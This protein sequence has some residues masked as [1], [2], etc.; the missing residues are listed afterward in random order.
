MGI[1]VGLLLTS[2]ADSALAQG[3][4]NTGLLPAQRAELILAQMSLDEKLAMVQAVKGPYVG[5]LTNNARLGIPALC[6]EDG[7]AGVANGTRG[8]TAFPAP[9]CIGASWDVALARDYGAQAAREHRHKGVNVMLAPMMNLARVPQSG[10][11]F[12]GYGEEPRLSGMLAAAE[13]LGIQGQGTMA[14]IKHFVGNDQETDRGNASSDMDERTLQEVYNEPFRLCVRAGAASVMASYN[15][16]HL[17]FACESEQLNAT[18]KKRWGFDGFVETDWYAGFST[19]GGASH[20]LDIEMYSSGWFGRG[21]LGTA[22]QAG[23]VPVSDLD[24]MVRRVLGAMFRFGLFDSPPSGSLDAVVTNVAH[25]QFARDA[26]AQGMVL[27]KN[28]GNLLPLSAASLRSIAVIGS[29]ADVSPISVGGGSA[30]V[31]LPYNITPRTGI[32]RRAGAVTINYAQGDGA[33]LSLAAQAAANSDVAIVC[34]GRQTSEGSD[35]SSLSLP[36]NQD[37][38]ISAVA[39]ANP[40]TIVVLYASGATL[41]PWASQ[42]AGIVVA[43]FPGQENGSALASVLFGDVNPSGKLPVTFPVLASQVPAGTPSRFP[44]VSGHVEYS[45]GLQIGYRWYDA[46]NVAPLFCFGHGLSYTTFG[47]SNLTVSAVNAAGQVQIGFDL[48]NTGSRAGAEVAQLYLGYPAAANEPPKLLKRFQKVTLS[49]GETRHVVFHLNWEDMAIWDC[50]ARGWMVTPGLFQVLV[51]ASSRDLR[52]AGAFTMPSVPP[53]DLANAALHR[54]ATASSVLSTNAAGSLCV[55]GDPETAWNSQSGG[56]QSL[57]LDLGMVRDLS[58]IRLQWATNYAASYAI[59]L[60]RDGLNWSGCRTNNNGLGGV[61]DLLVS[62]RG[63]YVRLDCLTPGV[64]G[65]GYS[66]AE[67]E[68]FS[69]PQ[70]PFGGNVRAVPGV[71][72][73]EDF[74]AGGQGVAYFNPGSGNS[75]GAYRTDAVGIEPAA[76]SGAGY[77][78]NGLNAGQWLEYMIQAPDP[79]AIYNVSV[80]AASATGGGL[81]RVRLDGV[82]LGT[83]A[84]PVT[85]GAQSWQTFWLPKVPVSGATGT[86]ALRLEVL[87]GGFSLNWI[88]LDRAAL[89]GTNNLAYNRPVSCSSV[90]STNYPASNAVDGDPRTRWASK[91]GDPQWLTVDLGSNCPLARIRLNWQVAFARGFQ[92]RVSPD[93]GS[94]TEVYATTTNFAI[95]NDLAVDGMARYV[96]VN[97]TQGGTGSGASLWDFEV[98]PALKPFWSAQP[99]SQYTAPGNTVR[100]AAALVGDSPVACQWYHGSSLIPG[101]N[102]TNLVLVNVTAA[103]AGGYWVRASNATANLVSSVARIELLP[104]T[105]G[106]FALDSAANYL[107][108]LGF[109]GNGGV[110][111]GSWTLNAS[112]GGSYISGDNPPMFGLWNSSA[113]AESTAARNFSRPLRPGETFSVQLRMGTLEQSTHRNG[114]Q[115]KDAAGKV[116]FSYYHQGGDYADGHYT[117]DTGTNLARGFAY[118]Y[119]QT[120]TFVFTL[121]S[122]TSYVFADKATGAS[123]QGR[124]APDASISQ[125]TFFRANLATAPANG[126]DFKFDA[127]RLDVVPVSAALGLQAREQGWSASFASAPGYAYRVQ[128]ATDLSGP[129]SVIGTV[130]GP[131]DGRSEF[132]DTNG[133]SERAFYRTVVP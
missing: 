119:G 26:A 118:D 87:S 126:Q 1:L 9:L 52:L 127:L 3:W 88:A 24:G 115:L 121:K 65:K 23:T 21:L 114:F 79:E 51:G 38:L 93:G 99:A 68:V 50:N 77:D 18:L 131:Q 94:W 62:G 103:D 129:W 100:L 14:N 91:S 92:V 132:V 41:M 25:S 19:Q 20:G 47:Y 89:C 28:A 33:S 69:Q 111:F 55:D 29:A 105:N 102:G 98:Y 90:E 34:V 2:C 122:A 48:T 74:D 66:L 11:N 53:S 67:L 124:L 6:F 15:R 42:V 76:D 86:R 39:A 78:V 46:N 120:D 123:F 60:S 43:W 128:R 58:R 113:A 30:G 61:E 54:L 112:G 16:L 80:R 13:V 81:L 107:P 44:G 4:T 101:A 12:E 49:P 75:T 108:A 96:R 109:G 110:G 84:I 85:G 40:R 7:P 117:D 10:R 8:V 125:V 130:V 32:A 104:A 56:A 70:Q 36:N 27:L 64:P 97:T 17:R 35:R 37:A 22:I 73:A 31:V 59:V 63:R 71:I 5:M 72:Q 45:E 95:L 116:L 57:A 106:P 133:P 82:V 83:L